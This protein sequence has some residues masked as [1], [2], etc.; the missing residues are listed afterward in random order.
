MN[1][2]KTDF[3]EL[4]GILENDLAHKVGI[5]NAED[6][7]MAFTYMSKL[8][9]VKKLLAW[10]EESLKHD[11]IVQLRLHNFNKTIKKDLTPN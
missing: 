7:Y 10:A 3:L 4:L 11:G 8:I 6:T 5:C 9:T 2:D 1:V